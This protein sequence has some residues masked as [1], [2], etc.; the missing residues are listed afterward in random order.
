MKI[1]AIIL[2]IH[3]LFVPLFAS[4]RE[5]TDVIVMQNGD[6]FTGEVKALNAGVLYVSLPYVIQTLSVDWSKVKRLESKQLFFV[7]TEDGS[8]YRGVLNSRETA[9]GRPI[10]IE[11]TETPVKNAVISSAQVV[12]V[13][14]TSEKFRQRFTGGVSFGTIYTKANET[15]QYNVS[16]LAAYPRERWG[17]QAGLS[18]NL[19]SASSTTTSTR[20]Q[21][22]F[23]GYHLMRW[24]NYY[25]SGFDAFLQST[26]QGITRQNAIGGGIGRYLKNTNS[27]VISV[28]GGVGWQSSIY[29]QNTVPIPTQNDATAVIIA[30]M[31]LFKFNKT[32]FDITATAFP[33]LT[34][35]GR[36]KLSTNASYY[37]KLIGNLSWNVSFYGNWD[38]QPPGNLPGSDYGS[39]SGLSWTF[40]SSLRTSPAAIQ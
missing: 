38:N 40:G 11:I 28:M 32:T 10:E 17:A 24:N 39:S 26:E 25:Y 22:T 13:S 27:T 9:A 3:L 1:R 35:P 5:S 20:N 37:I 12:D 8:V 4:A 36:L 16:G 19:S 29:N 2:F 21:L 31:Q 18:S 33:F 30:N 23:G 14:Q 15:A 6:R 34:E 7:K